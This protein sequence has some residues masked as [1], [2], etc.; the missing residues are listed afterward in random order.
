[1]NI[2]SVEPVEKLN[3]MF[4]Y[5]TSKSVFITTDCDGTVTL[6]SICRIGMLLNAFLFFF[7]KSF[8]AW[9]YDTIPS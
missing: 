9:C 5:F 1:M 8:L 2:H 6:T 4:E 3:C 7:K